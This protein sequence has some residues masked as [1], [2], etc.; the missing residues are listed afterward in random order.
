MANFSISS[1]RALI[2]SDSQESY[3]GTSI[4]YLSTDGILS[5]GDSIYITLPTAPPFS[6]QEVLAVPIAELNN[7]SIQATLNGAP[8]PFTTIQSSDG[9]A[10]EYFYPRDKTVDLKITISNAAS[11]DNSSGILFAL[12]Q[13]NLTTFSGYPAQELASFAGVSIKPNVVAGLDMAFYPGRDVMAA[14]KEH[15]NLAVVGY[16]LDPAPSHNGAAV[17]QWTGRLSELQGQGW[18]VNPIY[19]GRQDQHDPLTAGSSFIQ[20]HLPAAQQGVID[21]DQ[22]C[23]DANF[24]GVQEFARGTTIYLDVESR[25]G[26]DSNGIPYTGSDEITYIESW[27]AE[28]QKNNGGYFHPGIYTYASTANLI[29]SEVSAHAPGTTY[30]ITDN[31][32]QNTLLASIVTTG[33]G[34]T[35]F[36]TFP[37]ND[38]SQSDPSA[39]SKGVNIDG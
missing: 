29:A 14:L 15:T 8:A 30:W 39:S 21:A 27:C 12:N 16:Y 32:N 22:A 24:A 9:S 28:V 35:A 34:T 4:E 3:Y 20:N 2:V 36:T 17:N 19:V 37:T 6:F 1:N 38:P 18:I 23:T 7:Y 13:M 5:P 11:S 31:T 25:G 26:N 10:Y 33:S